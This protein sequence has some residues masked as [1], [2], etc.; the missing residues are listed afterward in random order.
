MEPPFIL[1]APLSFAHRPIETFFIVVSPSSSMILPDCLASTPLIS[2]AVYPSS[3]G[4][5][6]ILRALP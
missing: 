6:V 1:M 3:I 5:P 4:G 2:F